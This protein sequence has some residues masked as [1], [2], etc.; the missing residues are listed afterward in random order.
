MNAPRAMRLT[1]R[2]FAI[3]PAFA[4][5]TIASACYAAAL[6]GM[7]GASASIWND[8]DLWYFPGDPPYAD[9]AVDLT[10]VAVLA[11]LAAVVTLKAIG[12][13][14]RT[15]VRRAVGVAAALVVLAGALPVAVIAGRHMGEWA[16]L[17]EVIMREVL[18]A[19]GSAL[20]SR[21]FPEA[22]TFT[23]SG[24]STPVRIRAVSTGEWPKVLLDFGDGGNAEFDLRT[25]YCTYSD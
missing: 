2:A 23:F 8:P 22:R 13:T 21:S 17:R 11:L 14:Q 15:R 1:I 5:L 24:R 4:I 19:R 3:A 10:G 6:A 12:A 20:E 18:D 25:M 7:L 9:L 16:T